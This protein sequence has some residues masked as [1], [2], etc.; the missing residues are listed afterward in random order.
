VSNISSRIKLITLVIGDIVCLGLI[1][2][3]GFV[4]HGTLRSAGLR[5][6]STFIP[7]MIAWFLVSPFLGAY[8]L[9]RVG[10]IRDLWRP[11][12]AMVLA[13]PLAA[14]L[15]GAWLNAAIIPIF[16]VVLAGF[17]AIAVLVWRGIFLLALSRSRHS[18]G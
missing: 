6:L 16:V 11:F 5:M 18:H 4:R 8:D 12:R 3:S 15:R 1:T 2:V 7:V 9:E 17:N 10:D 14:W 13:A